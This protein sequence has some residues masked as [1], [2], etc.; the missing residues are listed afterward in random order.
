MTMRFWETFIDAITSQT[1]LFRHVTNTFPVSSV[2]VL[3]GHLTCV[4]LPET[5]IASDT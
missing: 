3:Q 2:D 4:P 5:F 1:A